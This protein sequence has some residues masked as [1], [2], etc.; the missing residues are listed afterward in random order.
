MEALINFQTMVADLT[1]MEIANASLLDEATAAAEA[2]TLAKRSR[3]VEVQH[4]PGGRRHATRRPSRCCRPAPSR[5]ASKVNVVRGTDAVHAAIA[6]G[7][8]FGVLLQYPATSGWVADWT[9]RSPRPSTRTARLVV[10]ATDLL[11]LTLLEV[12]GRDGRRHRGRQQPA[13]RRAVRL[14]RPARRVHG[15]P[16]RLQALACRAA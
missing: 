5:W 2:M 16:R 9:R 6:E 4:L 10:V 8:Y 1:G 13:L 3:Q 11:A 15:L 12:A 7:D 14:R